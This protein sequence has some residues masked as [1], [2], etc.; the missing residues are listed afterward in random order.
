MNTKDKV[1]K[2]YLGDSVYADF[3]GYHIVVTTENWYGPTNTVFLE[4]AAFMNLIKYGEKMFNL[5]GN[6][7][8][9]NTDL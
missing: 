4:F 3:D 5:K 7:N 9:N 8:E 6:K 2:L 1:T